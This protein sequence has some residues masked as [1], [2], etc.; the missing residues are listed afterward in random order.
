MRSVTRL[1]SLAATLGALASN[2][3]AQLP[4]PV[5]TALAGGPRR[6]V[7]ETVSCELSRIVDGD[8]IECS[9]QGRVRLIGIDTPELDQEPFGAMA[10]AALADLLDS[11]AVVGLEPDVEARDRYGRM[12]A[13]VWVDSTMVNWVLI[14]QGWA[15]LLT[16]PPNVQ[17]VDALTE[18]QRRAREEGVGLWG[19]GG[20]ECLPRERRRGRC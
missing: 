14:R 4:E 5:D 16:Y 8:T 12:L 9:E 7:R 19:V 11:P 10:H 2:S 18:A 6:P 1:L 20:F 13:Y 17:Y 3:V 15:V